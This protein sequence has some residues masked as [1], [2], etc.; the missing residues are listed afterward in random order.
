MAWRRTAGLAVAGLLV[1][2]A[3]GGGGDSAP[4]AARA[5]HA[6]RAAQAVP[7]DPSLAAHLRQLQRIAS[8]HGGTRAASTPGDRATA[9]YLLGRLRAAGLRVRTQTVRFP[10]TEE[11]SPPRVTRVDGPDRRLRPNRDVR[12]LQFSGPA[13]LTARVRAVSV[14]PGTAS[15]SGCAASAFGELRRGEI[16]L[17]QRGVCTL[18]RKALNAQRAGAGAVLIL[19]DG[20][21]GRTSTFAGTLGGPGV[22]IA[23]LGLSTEAGAA[24]ARAPRPRLRLLV[25]AVSEL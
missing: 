11:R 2:G 3:C 14:A 24:L 4:H 15:S 25:R 7:A 5:A 6:T 19:N 22:R 8:A 1:V 16:A 9:D 21:P 12:T 17:L 23:V 13:D 18:R 20:L 10:F